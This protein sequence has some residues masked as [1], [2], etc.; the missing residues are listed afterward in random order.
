M[1]KMCVCVWACARTAYTAEVE[2]GGSVICHVWVTSV[3]V[4]VLLL[5]TIYPFIMS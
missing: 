3:T 2:P 4:T 1:H 5:V